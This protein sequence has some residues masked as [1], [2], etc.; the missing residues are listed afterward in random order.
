MSFEIV[1][2]TVDLD[3][4]AI[5]QANEVNNISLAWG[6]AAEMISALSP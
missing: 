4:E 3:N 5:L 6:L 2:T 1:L